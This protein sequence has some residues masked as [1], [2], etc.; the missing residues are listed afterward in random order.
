[1]Y[2]NMITRVKENEYWAEINNLSLGV[3]LFGHNGERHR[4]PVCSHDDINIPHT[5]SY[6]EIFACTSESGAVMTS[7]GALTVHKDDILLIPAGYSHYAVGGNA[8]FVTV[9]VFG[10]KNNAKCEYDLYRDLSSVLSLKSVS[11]YRNAPELCAKIVGIVR[12]KYEPYSPYPSLELS[13]VV[14][15]LSDIT[16]T[17]IVPKPYDGNSV[18]AGRDITRYLAIEHIISCYTEPYNAKEIADRLYMTRRHLDRIVK[19]HYGKTLR[20][21]VTEKRVEHAKRLLADTD[22]SVEKIGRA[23]GFPSTVSFKNSFVALTGGSPRE[24]RIQANAEKTHR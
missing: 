17:V 18:S 6:I 20:E 4:E 14:K 24:Y 5:H 3:I 23:V 9:G 13:F 21:L 1:M 19:A 12:G 2:G 11:V 22:D 15:G 10:E 7:T 8:H 16:P